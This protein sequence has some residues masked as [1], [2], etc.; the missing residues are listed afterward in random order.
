MTSVENLASEIAD[1]L[2]EVEGRPI[3]VGIDGPGGSGKS[4]LARLI[5]Q[6]TDVATVVEAD[7][8]Y[9]PSSER[10]ED[11]EPGS[12]YDW[13]RLRDQVLTPLRSNKPGRY[14]RYDWGSDQLAEW[15]DIPAEGVVVIE[16]IYVLREELRDF[17]DYTIWV[18]APR[19]LR[20]ARGLERDGENKRD[21]WEKWMA[22]EDCYVEAQHPE[23]S[24]DRVVNGSG[25][26]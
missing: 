14:Q 20:L 3:L 9:L 26:T 11:G 6:A 21:W 19:E 1:E 25:Q 15:H 18:T 2:P 7:D 10:R 12:A 17:Y 8:F 24:V 4:T 22:L 16:G 23:Q 5:A 13:R